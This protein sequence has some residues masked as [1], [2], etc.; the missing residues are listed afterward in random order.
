MASLTERYQTEV[1]LGG[2]TYRVVHTGTVLSQTDQ[3]DR[4]IGVTTGAF[5]SLL[6]IGTDGG[7]QMSSCDFLYVENLDAMNYVTLCVQTVGGD[8]MFVKVPAGRF[9]KLHGLS[10]DVNTSG[11]TSP[12]L[13]SWDKV[14][15]KADTAEVLLR[16]VATD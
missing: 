14:Q 8:S 5:Q 9:F 13:G 7:A 16:V 12:T 11:T 1:T 15:A 10:F 4:V 2:E 6:T 3:F